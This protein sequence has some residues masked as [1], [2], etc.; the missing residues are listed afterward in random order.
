MS[1]WCWWSSRSTPARWGEPEKTLTP[2][3]LP[4]KPSPPAPSPTAVGEG[5]PIRRDKEDT[6][7]LTGSGQTGP[8]IRLKIRPEGVPAGDA[9]RFEI[10]VTL[11]GERYVASYFQRIEDTADVRAG[12]AIGSSATS[13][14]SAAISASPHLVRERCEYLQRRYQCWRRECARCARRLAESGWIQIT[15]LT[16]PSSTTT[17]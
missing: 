17:G 15:T 13:S 5:E 16:W 14:A 9:E 1:G 12:S 4:E 8:V 11:L 10:L 2:A 6:M 7:A 3:P